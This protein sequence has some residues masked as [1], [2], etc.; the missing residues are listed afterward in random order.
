[1]F[2]IN[3][4]DRLE[5]EDDFSYKLRL[6]LAKINKDIDLDWAEIVEL[7]NIDVSA[8]H[9]RKTAYGL[10][11]YY[12]YLHK[13]NGKVRI[14]SI[15]DLHV[16]YQLDY[17]LLKDYKDVDILQINGDICDCQAISKFPKAY[18]VSSMQ[19]IIMTRQYLIELINY[20]RPKKTILT[21]GNHDIR[22]Q[23]YFANK[24]ADSDLL[25]LNPL[26][27]IEL[28]VDDGFNWYDK[29]NGTKTHYDGIKW[30]DEINSEVNYVN[31]WY[32]QIGDT[33]FC[34]PKAFKSGIMKT[35]ET[36]MN[37]FRNEGYQFKT[38]VMAHTHR[39]GQ[40]TIGNTTLYEQGCFCDTK[41]NNYTDGQLFNSQ[42]EGFLYLEQDLDGNTINSKLVVLN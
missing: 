38:L 25:E 16:P 13:P 12:D 37:F 31:N 3:N 1:M 26:T 6:C 41:K 11:E 17:K 36:A 42:K 21:Y 40:Y 14:L 8:D 9:L 2:I 29:K 22:F 32:C 18:R 34:H 20:I 23:N 35:A 27:S 24:L 19:E 39:S 10:K 28:I 7:L 5:N 30:I 4:L 33:I 15:S